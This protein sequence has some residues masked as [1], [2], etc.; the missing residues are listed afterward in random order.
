MVVPPRIRLFAPTISWAAATIT[1]T[2]AY[3]DYGDY[4]K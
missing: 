3:R 2:L 1:R 4:I